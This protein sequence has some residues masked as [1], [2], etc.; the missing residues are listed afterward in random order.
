MRTGSQFLAGTEVSYSVL[1]VEWLAPTL[2][3]TI[4]GRGP[5]SQC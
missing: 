3:P 1:F 4:G 2:Y 5:Y